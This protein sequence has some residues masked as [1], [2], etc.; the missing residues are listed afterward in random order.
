MLR[1]ESFLFCK[2]LWCLEVDREGKAERV[3]GERNPLPPHPHSLGET[4]WY[5]ISKVS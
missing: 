5:L 1:L 3:G 2:Y 4:Y